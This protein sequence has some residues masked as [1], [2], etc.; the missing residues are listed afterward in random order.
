MNKLK[1]QKF[2]L[3]VS[4]TVIIA[5]FLTIP[6][7]VY[8]QAQAQRQCNQASVDLCSPHTNIEVDSLSTSLGLI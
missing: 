8:S 1:K 7:N 6:I 4:S 2:T 3:V 5:L